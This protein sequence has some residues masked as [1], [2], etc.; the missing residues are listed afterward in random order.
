MYETS[1]VIDNEHLSTLL[2]SLIHSNDEDIKDR[3]FQELVTSS[4]LIA[5]ID[6]QFENNNHHKNYLAFTDTAE[7]SKWCLDK[8]VPIE[9]LSY[10]ELSRCILEDASNLSGF[11]LNPNGAN[12]HIGKDMIHAL[13]MLKETNFTLSSDSNF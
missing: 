5:T 9:V 1:S 10:E 6:T 4:F 7:L 11:I 3:F 8:T 12:I 2:N 13:N